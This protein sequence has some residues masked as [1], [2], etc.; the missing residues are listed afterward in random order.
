MCTVLLPPGGSPIAVNKYIISYL[1]SYISYHISYIISYH[2]S[3]HTSY[4]TSYH[5]S[6]HISHHIFIFKYFCE[7]GIRTPHMDDAKQHYPIY[8]RINL[9]YYLSG[10]VS[11]QAETCCTEPCTMAVIFHL[12]YHHNWMIKIKITHIWSALILNKLGNIELFTAV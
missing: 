8:V 2:I 5:I 4:H 7:F 12:F 1:T 10:D 11:C 3:Y 6:Y 9:V